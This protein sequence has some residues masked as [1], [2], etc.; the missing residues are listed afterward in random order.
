M[1]T[2]SKASVHT[3]SFIPP[4]TVAMI[5]PTGVGASIGGYGGDATVYLNLLASCCDWLITHPNVANAASF[6]QLPHNAWYVEGY[7]LD[8]WFKGQVRLHTPQKPH[9]LGV[10]LD[11]GMEAGMKILQRNTI[12]AVNMV[13]GIPIIGVAETDEPLALTIELQPSGASAGRWGNPLAAINPA[14]TLLAKGA[15][16][17]AIVSQ[18]VEPEH[19]TYSQGVGVDPIGGLEAIISHTLSHALQVPCA[20]APVFTW[21]EAQPRRDA[22]VAPP[23]AAEFITATFLPCILTGLMQ[24]PVAASLTDSTEGISCTQLSALVVPANA[25]GG[26]PVLSAITHKIPIIAVMENTTV[27][28]MPITPLISSEDLTALKQQGLYFE[29]DSYLAAAGLLQLLRL[30][31]GLP[32]RIGVC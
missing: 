28:A 6:Q 3:T 20:N 15:T 25:M 18:L 27:L 10:L 23:T 12:N 13:Y 26:V 4:F 2:V 30:R 1:N 11:A 21:E 14:K 29:V 31:L 24:A 19:S 16:A 7:W 22:L 17:I 9:K 8:S 32:N 5:I